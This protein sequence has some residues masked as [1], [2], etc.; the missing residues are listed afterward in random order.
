MAP[1]ERRGTLPV[2]H[3]HAPFL[4][5]LCAVRPNPEGNACSWRRPPRAPDRSKGRGRKALEKLL[6]SGGLQSQVMLR[7]GCLM[8]ASPASREA[9]WGRTGHTSPSE[10]G[11]RVSLARSP[12]RA[13]GDGS[14]PWTYRWPPP[15][16]GGPQPRQ[17]WPL[18]FYTK[19]LNAWALHLDFPLSLR[20]EPT[21]PS[22]RDSGVPST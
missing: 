19:T 5:F 2:G 3:D 10:W 11:A 1:Q 7:R 21:P 17:P 13:V 12:E 14:P 8:A 6:K 18:R 15:R 20:P 16:A 4:S 22:A 9:S